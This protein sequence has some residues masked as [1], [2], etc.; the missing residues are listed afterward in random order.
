M[1]WNPSQYVV[2][3]VNQELPDSRPFFYPFKRILLSGQ[4]DG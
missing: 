3:W 1:T 4:Q 2:E